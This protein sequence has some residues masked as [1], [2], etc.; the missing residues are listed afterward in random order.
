MSSERSWGITPPVSTALP[1]PAETQASNALLEEL[2]QQGTF[3]SA[4]ETNT[5]SVSLKT[6]N[7]GVF[8]N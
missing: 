2:K 7:M 6:F 3:E 5:R 1:T 4:E 8:V